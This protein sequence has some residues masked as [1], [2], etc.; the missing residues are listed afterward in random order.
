MF[1]S[2]KPIISNNFGVLKFVLRTQW[3]STNWTKIGFGF[4]ATDRNDIEA[5]YLQVGKFVLNSDTGSLA[6][7][8]SAGKNVNFNVP[9]KLIEKSDVVNVVAFLHGF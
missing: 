7:N 2:V 9:L 1:F 8:C 6:A 5:G 3:S 4:L